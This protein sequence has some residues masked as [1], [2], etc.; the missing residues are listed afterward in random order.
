MWGFLRSVNEY[1]RV[2][3]NLNCER[4]FAIF[5]SMFF[6]MLSALFASTTFFVGSKLAA[7]NRLRN[8]CGPCSNKKAARIHMVFGMITRPCHYQKTGVL[9][10]HRVRIVVAPE[11]Q[12]RFFTDSN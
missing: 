1:N 9:F 6:S 8:F 4:F 2:G 10:E 7:G 3:G 12:N 11:A 5:F